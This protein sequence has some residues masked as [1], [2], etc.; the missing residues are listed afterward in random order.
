[1]VLVAAGADTGKSWQRV[2]ER[3]DRL[4]VS[5]GGQASCACLEYALIMWMTG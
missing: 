2:N 3:N 4:G 1:M 5:Q